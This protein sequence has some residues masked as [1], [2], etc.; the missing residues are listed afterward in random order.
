MNQGTRA[1]KSVASTS[2]R[3]SCKEPACSVDSH[4]RSSGPSPAP[5]PSLPVLA[6]KAR[7]PSH[8]VDHPYRSLYPI[9]DQRSSKLDLFVPHAH[10]KRSHTPETT[11]INLHNWCHAHAI[12]PCSSLLL[13]AVR[14]PGLLPNR[15]SSTAQHRTPSSVGYLEDRAKPGR[16]AETGPV[17]DRR[18]Y[19]P[20]ETGNQK[21]T[22]HQPFTQLLLKLQHSRSL[23]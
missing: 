23:P 7:Q 11:L 13:S 14:A 5:G 2:A 9:A 12:S 21:R 15:A 20:R 19:E 1:G 3:P 16:K 17:L 22:P 10:P 8:L 4:S 18:R 6:V